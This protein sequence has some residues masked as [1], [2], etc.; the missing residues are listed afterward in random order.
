MSTIDPNLSMGASPPT[1]TT[2]GMPPT[3]GGMGTAGGGDSK[4]DQAKE[5]AAT[6]AQKGQQVAQSAVQGA[7]EVAQEAKQGI[8]DVARTGVDEARRVAGEARHELRAQGDTQAQRIE[9]ALRTLGDQLRGAASGQ[10][11]PAGRG[12]DLAEQA[13]TTVSAWADR[14]ADGG[15]DGV[16]R[17]M[18]TF[19]RRRPGAFLAGAAVAGFAAG[20]MFRGAQAASS[21]DSGSSYAGG[22]SAQA[23][24]GAPPVAIGQVDLAEPMTS[25]DVSPDAALLLQGEQGQP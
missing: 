5:A 7:G 1:T 12:R 23:W 19:A 2:G 20:R 22:Q 13:S 8:G 14:L 3:T 10:P 25:L 9:G 4:S 17:D 16:L 11:I 6:A 18:G 24:T 15:V 21:D